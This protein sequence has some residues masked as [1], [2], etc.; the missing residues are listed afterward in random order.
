MLMIE[1]QCQEDSATE[2]A[3]AWIT[4]RVGCVH[5]N[6]IKN[7]SL[8]VLIILTLNNNNDSGNIQ[9][10]KSSFNNI[11]TGRCLDYW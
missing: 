8:R 5:P 3:Y 2:E 6:R 11:A 9:W 1:S 4:S 10:L 7:C